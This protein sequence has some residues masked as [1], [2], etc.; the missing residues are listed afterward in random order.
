[1]NVDVILTSYARYD[2]LEQT[3]ESFFRYND[4][5]INRF[6]IYEDYGR[7]R[8]NAAQLSTLQ[9]LKEKYAIDE[10]IMPHRRQGQI[11]ALDTLWSRVSTE[12]CFQMED[13]W[14][15]YRESWI[16]DSIAV[17]K[18]APKICTV[19]LRER[20]DLNGHPVVPLDNGK[21]DLLSREYQ[22]RW[23]G[24][25]FNPSVKRLAD[26]RL[27]GTYGLYAMFSPSNP[28]RSEMIIAKEYYKRGFSAAVLKQGYIRHIG[29]DGRGIRK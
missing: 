23:H 5:P 20:D 6:F 1:M 7:D 28:S 18:E 19:W 3:L 25:T 26:Y 10:V 11:K 24:F 29:G 4:F 12:Y 9:T 13:D 22:K 16:A 2:L 14:L 27:L 15:F 17:M 21:Y 8:M